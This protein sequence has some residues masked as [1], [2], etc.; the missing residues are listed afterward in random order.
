LNTTDSG[1][2]ITYFYSACVGIAS[3]DVRVL[4]D[5][6]FTEGIY[7]G[8]WFHYPKLE[9]PLE[10]IGEVEFI[11]VSH[12]HPDHYDPA[13]LLEYLAR[14]PDARVI[15]APFVPNYLSKLMTSAGIEH[16]VLEELTIGETKLALIL[17]GAGPP[18]SIDSALAMRWKDHSV[19]N[20]NDN[21]GGEVQLGQ[22]NDF[23]GSVDIAL[24]PYAGAGAWPQTYFERGPELL[25]AAERKKHSAF[26]RYKRIAAALDPKVRIPFAGKY[27][28]GGQL[29]ELNPLRG[30]PDAVEVLEFDPQ[31]V[32]LAD[33]GE[34]WIDTL[35]HTP[36]VART[37]PHDPAA[38][39]AYAASL[40]DH[41]MDY[42]RDF[43]E[44]DLA[45]V[46]FDT[47]FAR[48]YE[49]AHSRSTCESDWFFCIACG[50]R[51]FVLNANRHTP[52]LY[53]FDDVSELTPRSEIR[54][55]AR[56][57]YGLLTAAYHWNNAE[58]GSQ[59][60]TRRFPEEY[61]AEVQS[62]LNFL[63]V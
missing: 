45:T 51:W 62:F 19:I 18:S 25:A 24:L 28:L 53:T 4:C 56:Y 1:I 2:R 43:R 16:E 17:S 35:T 37:E 9:R 55:D 54:I 6:W 50:E 48:A 34:A 46:A 13:F 21:P 59:Y 60:E 7:D 20:F 14:Y 47:L 30:V 61:R 12:I 32:V 63:H 27:I 29:H 58:I 36:S 44:L 39:A 49:R 8:S 11:Y 42:E 10:K 31:A 3:P 38:V 22:L 41:E 23:C 5:P 52:E 40:A 57:L 33:G 15:I 26:D